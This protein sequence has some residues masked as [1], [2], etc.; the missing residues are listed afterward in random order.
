[1]ELVGTKAGG[2]LLWAG[3]HLGSRK[4]CTLLWRAVPAPLYA[5][6]REAQRVC[7]SVCGPVILNSP[8]LQKS[9]APADASTSEGGVGERMTSIYLS[10]PFPEVSIQLEPT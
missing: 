4:G 7:M 1:M 2:L 5:L 8:S 6:V 3:C 9:M 10:C